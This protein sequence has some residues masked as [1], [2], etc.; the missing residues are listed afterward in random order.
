MDKSKSKELSPEEKLKLFEKGR[1]RVSRRHNQAPKS[2]TLNTV[3]RKAG[4][5]RSRIEDMEKE[6]E[7]LKTEL[8]II[9]KK[10]DDMIAK[11]AFPTPEPKPK[12]EKCPTCGK[13]FKDLSRH[14]CKFV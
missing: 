9:T 6:M 7:I 11:E 2:A 4:A 12:K 1:N 3:S 5:N 8:A 10:V 13:E 14:K